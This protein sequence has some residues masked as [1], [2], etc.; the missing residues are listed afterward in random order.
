MD[1]ELK[2]KSTKDDTQVWTDLNELPEDENFNTHFQLKDLLFR[3]MRKLIVHLRLNTSLHINRLK[4]SEAVKRIS[5]PAEYM[6][7]NR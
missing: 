7:E 1:K 5:V 6:A 2:V 3:K 4:Y